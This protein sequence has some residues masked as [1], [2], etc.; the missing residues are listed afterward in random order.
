VELLPLAELPRAVVV[1]T[2]GNQEASFPPNVVLLRLDCSCAAHEY[3][4]KTD[5]A[6]ESKVPGVET[7]KDSGFQ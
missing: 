1:D 7:G 6:A 5:A 2:S 3:S 4:W